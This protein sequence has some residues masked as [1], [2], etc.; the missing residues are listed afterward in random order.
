[1]LTIAT[2]AVVLKDPVSAWSQQ[3]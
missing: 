2:I 3:R 1:M